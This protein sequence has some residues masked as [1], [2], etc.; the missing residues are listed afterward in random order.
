MPHGF[1]PKPPRSRSLFTPKKILQPGL[2]Q[3]AKEG[4]LLT[5]PLALALTGLGFATN[6]KRTGFHFQPQKNA[7]KPILEEGQ[8]LLE[9]STKNHTSP[10]N[11]LHLF[12]W[13]LH[14]PVKTP[15][16]LVQCSLRTEV[17]PKK[18]THPCQQLTVGLEKSGDLN[19]RILIF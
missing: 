13:S 10:R 15:T 7:W 14:H 9:N 4:G 3:G 1:Y 2:I 16:K 6:L 18:S 12:C 11:Q 19:I 5:A 17:L 8:K